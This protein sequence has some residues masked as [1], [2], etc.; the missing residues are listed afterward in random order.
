[1]TFFFGVDEKTVPFISS[2]TKNFF[3]KDYIEKID[4]DDKR[5]SKTSTREVAKRNRDSSKMSKEDQVNP[6]T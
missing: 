4:F 1:M 5:A 3:L 2:H 6:V